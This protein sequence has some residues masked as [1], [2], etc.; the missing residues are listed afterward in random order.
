MSTIY[1]CVCVSACTHVCVCVFKINS[2]ITSHYSNLK[3]SFLVGHKPY[4][5][6]CTMYIELPWRRCSLYFSLLLTHVFLSHSVQ[7]S[8]SM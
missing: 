5:I 6:N 4:L 2:G 1:M 8:L 3:F 7:F